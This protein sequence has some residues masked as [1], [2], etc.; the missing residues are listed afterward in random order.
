MTEKEKMLLQEIYDANNDKEI[1]SERQ[2][3]KSICYEYN[4]L[5]P[6]E[7]EKRIILLKNY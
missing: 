6:N 1:I 5:N 3:A 4:N 7:I 2:A